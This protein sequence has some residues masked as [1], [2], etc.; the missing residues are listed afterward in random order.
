MILSFLTLAR[1]SLTISSKTL[2]SML[3]SYNLLTWQLC[4]A[5]GTITVPSGC[6]YIC[7]ANPVQ[8][9]F[10]NNAETNA[11]KFTG[12]SVQA[13]GFINNLLNPGSPFDVV[14]DDC[15]FAGLFAN[16]TS[17]TKPLNYHSLI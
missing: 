11:W 3:Y 10:S 5:G 9:L 15:T 7:A 12:D 13:Y 14:Y 8:T 16:C 4:K 17:L 2:T 6:L 1:G